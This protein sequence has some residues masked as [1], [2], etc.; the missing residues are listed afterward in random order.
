MDAEAEEALKR[1]SKAF[2]AHRTSLNICLFPKL[3][4]TNHT[5]GVTLS[6]RKIVLFS[7]P[8]ENKKDFQGTVAHEYYHSTWMDKYQ[9]QIT[10]NLLQTIIFEGR[11]VYFQTKMYPNSF[12]FTSTSISKEQK[13]WRDV[14]KHLKSTTRSYEN[15]VM[16]GG[17]EFPVGFGYIVGYHIV[18]QYVKNHPGATIE[19]WSKI[20]PE[21]LYQ[22]SGYEKWLYHFKENQ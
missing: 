16:F 13:L 2:H 4:T 22:E 18:K 21:Q 12:D 6:K 15:K 19:D 5:A 8:K 1:S 20:S 11:A 9:K 3:S 17:G 14:R 10:F 7:K